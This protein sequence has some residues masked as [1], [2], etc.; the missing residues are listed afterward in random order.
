MPPLSTRE[1]AL[2][3]GAGC[4]AVSWIANRAADRE[5]ERRLVCEREREQELRGQATASRDG[6]VAMHRQVTRQ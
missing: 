2:A 4:A 1:I 3:V 6:L 5:R